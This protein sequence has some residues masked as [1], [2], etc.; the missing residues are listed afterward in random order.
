MATTSS[1]MG[2]TIWNN[3]NDVFDYTALKNNFEAIDRH[4]HSSTKGAQISTNGIADLSIS[5]AKIG[6]SQVTSAK[7]ANGTIVNADINSAAAIDLSKLGAMPAARLVRVAQQ[8]IPVASGGLPDWTKVAL[9]TTTYDTEA[10][11]SRTAMADLANDRI[12]ARQ[13]GFYIVQLSMDW[14]GDSSTKSMEIRVNGSSSSIIGE[15]HIPST[16]YT[17]FDSST[18][19]RTSLTG[20]T[21]LQAS[22]YVDAY[23]AWSGTSTAIGIQNARL[24]ITWINKQ[25]IT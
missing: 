5:T 9:D 1:N 19:I 18:R 8:T 20:F 4:D 3:A 15:N 14:N 13:A 23:A 2:L 22:D 6:D 21:Y 24:Q 7:I 10:L 12:Y 11:A 17:S 16:G 25:P